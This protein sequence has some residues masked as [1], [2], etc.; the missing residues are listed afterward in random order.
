M[1]SYYPLPYP[2]IASQVF[3]QLRPLGHALILD[4][5]YPESQ[6]GRYDIITAAP[7]KL[8]RL[9][10]LGVEVK[11]ADSGWTTVN[12]APFELLQHWL[13]QLEC[14]SPTKP[15][16]N[17]GLIGYF[18]YDLGR[19]FERLPSQAIDDIDLPDFQV[20]LYPQAVIID[21]QTQQ[22][23]LVSHPDAEPD[24]VDQFKN[25]L[26]NS[27]SDTPAGFELTEAFSSNVSEAQYISALQK[28]Q[29]YIIAGDCYQINFA[30]RFSAGYA[31]DPWQ[32]WK[33]LK[34]VAPTP[35]S[36]YIDLEENAVLS[37]SPERFLFCNPQG[38][39]ET[40]PIKGTRP[41]GKTS[42]EDKANAEDLVTSEKDR[43]ENVM[44]VDLLRNDI[45]K[46]CQPGS[47]KVPELFKLE[48][49]PN[50]HHLVS[51]ITG[52]LDSNHSPLDLLK[53]CFPGGSITGAPKIRAMEIIDELEPHR[54][55]LYCGSIAYMSACGQMDSSITIRTLVCYQQ[56]IH[57]WAGG[58][59][60]ADSVT[61]AEY[62]ETF[63]KVNN[64][65][66]KLEASI[67][68][69]TET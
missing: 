12:C 62:A 59:I 14:K 58:G 53:A 5:C 60:V 36:A 64:L 57:C 28:V 50:V 19:H 68:K 32:A 2:L 11:E 10:K 30:Q 17:G 35:F 42:A 31:G 25:C 54:R 20:G 18:S 34:Q 61:Q 9:S 16:F 45:S 33:Q 23:W 8:A 67:G 44:I 6:F 39:V 13:D 55:S 56:K 46:V 38:Q 51:S 43:A 27:E 29:D 3:E 41:R 66:K 21:H 40:R 69:K 24:T 65:L 49:Y 1:V 48:S 15:P 47:V 4:S 52:Q 37:L 63:S 7:S 22:S 26:A